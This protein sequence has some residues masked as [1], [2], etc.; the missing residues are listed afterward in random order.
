MHS[1]PNHKIISFSLWG[2]NPFYCKGMLHNVK[3]AKEIYPDWKVMVYLDSTVPDY[4]LSNLKKGGVII[5]EMDSRT[6][7]FSKALWRF[8]AIEETTGPVIFR[9][10]DSRLSVRERWAVKEWLKTDKKLH[11][12]REQGHYKL[13][14][15][16]MFGL[17]EI[18]F[19]MKE[20]MEK[21]LKIN[22]GKYGKQIDQ[23]FLAEV[24][25][26]KLNRSQIAHIS[27]ESSRKLQSDVFFD[28]KYKTKFGTFIG[29][30]IYEYDR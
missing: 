11:I 24:I 26:N 18:D 16:G 2:S 15:A 27:N 9:D 8:L 13:I 1:T 14:Q 19:S 6:S 23:E 4:Y 12:M 5:R 17:K 21:W 28:E 30:R 22:D 25:W 10:A 20:E 3:L 7:F 29:E